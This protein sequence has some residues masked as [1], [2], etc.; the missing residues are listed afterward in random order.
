MKNLFICSIVIILWSVFVLGASSMLHL[1]HPQK[2]LLPDKFIISIELIKK[3]NNFAPIYVIDSLRQAHKI[4]L[5]IYFVASFLKY[6]YLIFFIFSSLLLAIAIRENSFFNTDLQFNSTL[7]AILIAINSFFLI[8]KYNTTN[9]LKNVMYCIA[10]GFSIYIS[11]QNGYLAFYWLINSTI[12]PLLIYSR[13]KYANS[14]HKP[15]G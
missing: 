9:I 14:I 10:V 1:L 13:K 15:N 8:Y 4:P 6:F 3:H 12:L 5:E 11:E 2:Y 7:L